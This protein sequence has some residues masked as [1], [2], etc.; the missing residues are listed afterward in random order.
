MKTLLERVAD[1]SPESVTKS[2]PQTTRESILEHLRCVLNTRVGSVGT[3]PDYGLEPLA[4]IVAR[5][6]KAGV[7]A[8]IRRLIEAFEPRLEPG[9]EVAS[10]ERVTDPFVMR[11][12]VVCRLKKNGERVRFE[13]LVDSFGK[14]DIQN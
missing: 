2:T 14:V 11:L 7:V 12:E 8:A 5:S 13:T 4:D 1:L 9:V 3:R 10:F 6:G